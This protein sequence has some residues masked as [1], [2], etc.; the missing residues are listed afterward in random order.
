M[1]RPNLNIV[2]F[3]DEESFVNTEQSRINNSTF[4]K[5]STQEGFG[6]N[7]S[8]ALISNEIHMLREKLGKIQDKAHQVEDLVKNA[9]QNSPTAV[10]SSSQSIPHSSAHSSQLEELLRVVET[11]IQIIIQ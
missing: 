3:D 1:D 5:H 4:P 7:H 11:K 9:F 8:Q 10:I 6:V 2:L